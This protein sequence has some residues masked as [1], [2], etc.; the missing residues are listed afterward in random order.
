MRQKFFAYLILFIAATATVAMIFVFEENGEELSSSRTAFQ[1]LVPTPGYVRVISP[2][3]TPECSA[4]WPAP[5]SVACPWLA[6]PTSVSESESVYAKP[7]QWT[8][9]SPPVATVTPLPG[10]QFDSN[11]GRLLF[12]SYTLSGDD[13]AGMP[14]IE[15]VIIDDQNQ[16]LNA[17]TP[18]ETPPDQTFPFSQISASPDG[19]YLAGVLATQGGDV[20]NVLDIASNKVISTLGVGKY[21]GWHPNSKEILFYQ[22]M[23][24]E[25]GLWR[26]H[27]EYSTH[28]LVAQPAML[29]ITGAA[30][31]P[32]G[33]LLAYGTN[34]FDTH[35]IW[36]SN[37]DGSA[38][39]KLL[40]SDSVVAVWGW[41][42]SGQYLL[43]TGETAPVDAATE[44]NQQ[45]MDN[46][47]WLWNRYDHT[48][49]SLSSQ[50]LF[51]YGFSPVWSPTSDTIA[52]VG[53]IQLNECWLT[54]GSFRRDPLCIYR[55]TGV[56]AEHIGSHRVTL[57]AT[58]A[59]DPSWSPD[60]QVLAYS[61][62]RANEQVDI[63]W[64]DL[65]T[66]EV[67]EVTASSAIERSPGWGGAPK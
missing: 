18:L 53:A 45:D 65:K 5:P 27:V 12:A 8:P 64:R 25:P 32:D 28:K 3:P 23:G 42:P 36:I 14:S 34:S 38:P 17:P 16:I 1:S 60:G 58:D 61:F 55:G 57:V 41:S 52:Y 11:T 51:G 22:D 59:I 62:M 33:Q 56:Y 2:L 20:L 24:Q 47:L 29:D 10:I 44:Q 49:R 6:T 66:T 37:A 48:Y 15:F 31:S 46:Q 50:F 9:P 43:Y 63:G 40:E 67:A 39:A 4:I 30:I 26:F 7:T 54:D 21:F 35:Q 13:K 19:K